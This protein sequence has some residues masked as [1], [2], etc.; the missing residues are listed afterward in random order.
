MD[1]YL[2]NLIEGGENQRLDFKYCVSDSRK[3]A[4]TLSAFANSDGGILLIGVRDNGS[5]AGIRSEE[6]YYMVDT[7]AELFCRPKITYTI[8]QHQV[9]VKTILEVEVI[10]GDKRPYQA[11]DEDGRWMAYFRH[12]DQNLLA[13]KVLLQVW[14]KT[15]KGSG[16]LV[17]FGKAEKSLMQYLT[18]NGSI[19]FSRFR[20]IAHISSYRAEMILANLIIFNVLIMNASEKGFIYELNPE[21][22]GK[23]TD[24]DLI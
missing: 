17:K 20:K 10:K 8:K 11:K 13:N 5:I 12:H 18:D 14:R 3:I 1:R 24:Q 16:V 9:G 7:A 15:E 22:P 19:T 4:R 21:D 6:E 23:L 2:K